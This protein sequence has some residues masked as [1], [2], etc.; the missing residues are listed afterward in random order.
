MNDDRLER[1]SGQLPTGQPKGPPLESWHPPLSGTIDITIH[2]D[3][4]WTHEGDPIHREA[5]VRLFASI[6]RREDDGEYYLVTP[7]EKWRIKVENLP[8]LVADF[9]LLESGDGAVLQVTTNTG[10]RVR[11]GSD[12]PLH[13]PAG[14]SP[15]SIPA[16]ALDHGLAAQFT[17]AAWYR[18][19][20]AS[21][22]RDGVVGIESQGQFFPLQPK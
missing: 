19:V 22:E 14:A 10:Q 3:G 9:D 15:E 5:L 13:F 21:E 12:Y 16:V 11:V 2:R 8:L 18:L 17:R 20:D 4:S 6:L 1:L 7:V